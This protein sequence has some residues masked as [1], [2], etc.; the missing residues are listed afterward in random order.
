MDWA[1]EA[2]DLHNHLLARQQAVGNE[3]ASSDGDLSVSHDCSRW[4][5]WTAK[6]EVEMFAVGG[7][8]RGC[9]AMCRSS[10]TG[11][12]FAVRAWHEQSWRTSLLMN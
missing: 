3:L 4:E 11:A 7:V 5:S 9:S 6:W 1:G 12:D 2:D 8:G 10:W